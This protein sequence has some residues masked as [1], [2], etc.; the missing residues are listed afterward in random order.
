MRLT[1]LSGKIRTT[2]PAGSAL[3][4]SDEMM[5]FGLGSLVLL[6]ERRSDIEQFQTFSSRLGNDDVACM[7]FSFGA[8]MVSGERGLIRTPLE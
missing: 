3:L 8:E 5:C 7:L 6:H 1:S 2:K 4:L